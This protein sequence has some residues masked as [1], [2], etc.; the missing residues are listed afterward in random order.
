MDFFE[1]MQKG[2]DQK[3][4]IMSA[5]IYTKYSMKGAHVRCIGPSGPTV[6]GEAAVV[7][8]PMF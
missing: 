3:I 8:Q 1:A 4:C 5:I 7:Q 2:S 6:I